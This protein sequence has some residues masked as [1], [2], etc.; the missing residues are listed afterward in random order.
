MGISG[1]ACVKD[2]CVHMC[3]CACLC[4]GVPG[5]PGS[6]QGW[7]V[8]QGHPAKGSSTRGLGG[9]DQG[10]QGCVSLKSP[11]PSAS[12]L[13]MSLKY[14]HLLWELPAQLPVVLGLFFSFSI[15][16]VKIVIL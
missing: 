12:A 13:S 1:Q 2:V 5:A 9:T 4:T 11:L 3:A 10:C 6:G 14:F 7:P 8:G 15:F 16:F